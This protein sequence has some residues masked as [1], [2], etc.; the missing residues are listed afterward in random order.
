MCSLYLPSKSE[1]YTLSARGDMRLS[2]AMRFR[3]SSRR[4]LFCSFTISMILCRF[5]E[6]TS[7][8]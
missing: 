2:L 1:P 5:M 8:N 4:H 7:L 6:P 3:H